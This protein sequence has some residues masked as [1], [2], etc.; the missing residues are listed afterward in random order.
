MA[1]PYYNAYQS[2]YM[3]YPGYPYQQTYQ[4]PVQT[5]AQTQQPI[6]QS[7]II[8]VQNG[9]A[10]AEQYPLAPNSAV[11][12]WDAKQPVIYIKQADATGRAS[13]RI[14]DTKERT[15]TSNKAEEEKPA[16]ANLATREDIAA[17]LA[18]VQHLA[19]LI[20]KEDA[21]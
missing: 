20:K 13:I 7:G 11:A 19:D 12:L 18:S 5:P 14:L 10:E 4:Q 21:E 1:Y 16:Q 3:S 6:Q 2:G 17:V 15:E 9:L 8:W